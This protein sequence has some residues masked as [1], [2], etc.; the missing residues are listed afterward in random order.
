[1]NKSFVTLAV[2]SLLNVCGGCFGRHDFIYL[3]MYAKP[4]G[5]YREDHMF[6]FLYDNILGP[7]YKKGVNFHP[8]R[9]TFLDEPQKFSRKRKNFFEFEK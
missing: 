9:Q 2:Q 7:L 4:Y 1:M 6:T 3:S 5:N 8:K